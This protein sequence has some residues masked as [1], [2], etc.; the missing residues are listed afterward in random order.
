MALDP[1]SLCPGGTGKKLKFCCTDLHV[2]LEKAHRMLEGDQAAACLEYV[3]KLDAA[4]PGRPCLLAM[5]ADLEIEQHQDDAAKATIASFREQ[6]P[7]N[8][9]ALAD[10]AILEA[11]AGNTTV[12]VDYLQTALEAGG[13]QMM[14]SV[15]EALGVVA[16]AL[17][18]GNH[19]LGGRAHLMLQ[20]GLG[21]EHDARP[22]STLIR[23]NSS[24]AL[25]LL[26]KEAH[27]LSPCPDGVSWKKA[28]DHAAHHA[29]HAEWRVAEREFAALIPN[30]GSSPAIW[31]NLAIL[32]GWL[33][34]DTGAAEAW[35]KYASLDVP[36]DDAIEGE[37]TAQLLGA[38]PVGAPLDL[39]TTEY[40]ITDF[41]ELER[42]LSAD[43]HIN[44]MNVDLAR[45]GD[46][47]QPPP[48][49]AF[50]LLDRELPRTGVGLTRADVPNVLGQ[51][52]VFGKE[53]DR[54]ARVEFTATRDEKYAAAQQ[55]LLSLAGG[56]LGTATKETVETQTSALKHALTWNWRLPDD[57]PPELRKS[58]MAEQ[59][60]V[61]L[62]ER[63]PATPMQ[64]LDGQT[65][66]AAAKNPAYRIR[67]LAAIL[68][69]ELSDIGA[70]GITT[71]QKLR[72]QL[73]LPVAAEI[74]PTSDEAL[75]LPLARLHRV[76]VE[77]LSKD[78]LMHL[79][80]ATVTAGVG[81]AG[82]KL[83]LAILA[84]KAEYEFDVLDAV[85]HH[86]VTAT[87]DLDESLKWLEEGRNAARAAGR[88]LGDWD[89]EELK[90]RIDRR[91][92][93]PMI[94]VMNRIA[95]EH[96]NDQRVMQQFFSILTQLGMVGPDGS[97]RIPALP[98]GAAPAA[99][100]PAASGLWTPGSEAGGSGGGGE[101][102]K[103]WLPGME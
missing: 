17:L 82:R 8:P 73:G 66:T 28:F 33:G 16:N 7:T 12:A 90:L 15:Y 27:E 74:R 9:I 31:R 70:E 36:T 51:F 23:L 96:R 25:P 98:A 19:L 93:E 62:L 76:V 42:R 87:D 60:Q 50:W 40:P 91:E 101:K 63:W 83:G 59:A 100:A 24:S 75:R 2:E 48:R 45:L 89:I 35:R 3:R 29:A 20:A 102:G 68:N 103:L 26:F 21:A 67:L 39:V 85:Y 34:N 55:A 47:G 14:P 41:D 72:A 52:F 80:T 88:P 38:D 4:H 81:A 61:M 71:Y 94:V 84:R 65:P 92:P 1:Y 97:L 64:I 69:L 13:Q 99:S 5:K 77:S 37:A 18:R 57:T 54:P 30:A 11:A 53:T 43:R 78:D 22:M 86:Q 44:R 6:F 95:R 10:S 32:R 46:D 49:G 58:L 79:Y 56:L